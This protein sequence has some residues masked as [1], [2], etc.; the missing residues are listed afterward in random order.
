MFRL[1]NRYDTR[2]R[3]TRS[4]ITH[5]FVYRWRGGGAHLDAGLVNEDGT[6]R[7]AFYVVRSFVRVNR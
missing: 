1:A 3:G 2:R 7:R 6:P 4:H 5:L